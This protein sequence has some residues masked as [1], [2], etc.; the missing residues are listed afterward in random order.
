MKH[1]FFEFLHNVIAHPLLFVALV[2]DFIINFPVYHGWLPFHQLTDRFH[3]W[4]AD[5]MEEEGGHSE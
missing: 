3:D 1:F 4:T 2:L 5:Q